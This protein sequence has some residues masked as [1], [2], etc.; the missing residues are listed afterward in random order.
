MKICLITLDSWINEWFF[1]SK[2]LKRTLFFFFNIVRSTIELVQYCVCIFILKGMSIHCLHNCYLQGENMLLMF[3]HSPSSEKEKKNPFVEDIR[4]PY[5][6]YMCSASFILKCMINQAQWEY[7]WGHCIIIHCFHNFPHYLF[8][9][10]FIPSAKHNHNSL[11]K[12]K[13]KL[14]FNGQ[15]S[16]WRLPRNYGKRS[17]LSVIGE[18]LRFE[19][20]VKRYQDVGITSFASLFLLQPEDG[21]CDYLSSSWKLPVSSLHCGH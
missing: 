14:S 13:R 19:Q 12:I 5:A 7:N 3:F 21:Y 10:D 11:I 17:G 18:A 8:Q 2:M 20:Q 9:S 15:Q 16:W 6:A 4:F 1:I